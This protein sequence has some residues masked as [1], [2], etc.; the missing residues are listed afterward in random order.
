MYCHKPDPTHSAGRS[1]LKHCNKHTRQ[2]ARSAS[3][4]QRCLTGAVGLQFPVAFRPTDALCMTVSSMQ[5]LSARSV[6]PSYRCVVDRSLFIHL[7]DLLIHN[8]KGSAQCRVKCVPAEI[9]PGMHQLVHAVNAAPTALPTTGSPSQP[10][11]R[12]STAIQHLAC[13]F[14]NLPSGGNVLPC[15]LL[16]SSGDECYGQHR[17]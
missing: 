16:S 5:Q 7:T 10:Y 8:V 9:W 6:Q 1:R 13:V 11:N 17:S 3:C 2:P 14:A 12:C 4:G 15:R